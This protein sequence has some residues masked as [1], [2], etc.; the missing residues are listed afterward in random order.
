MYINKKTKECALIILSH[1][2]SHIT[3]YSAYVL[4]DKISRLITI[5]ENAGHI[6]KMAAMPIYRVE[7]FKSLN[8]V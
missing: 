8:F 4:E 6:T 7:S 3:S 2:L 5:F 1:L